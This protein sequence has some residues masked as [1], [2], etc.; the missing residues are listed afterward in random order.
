MINEDSSGT[1]VLLKEEIKRLKNEMAKMHV[2]QTLCR[3][4]SNVIAHEEGPDVEMTPLGEDGPT[5]SRRIV[6]PREGEDLAESELKLRLKKAEKTMHNT[7]MNLGEITRFYE[8]DV[9][10]R[11]TIIG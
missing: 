2:A 1:L 9:A 7:L 8:R 5:P 4:C 3:S 11:D 10:D 6:L